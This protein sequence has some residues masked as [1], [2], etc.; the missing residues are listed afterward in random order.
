MRCLDAK[1]YLD[2]FGCNVAGRAVGH[3]GGRLPSWGRPPGEVP[4]DPVAGF[5]STWSDVGSVGRRVFDLLDADVWHDGCHVGQLAGAD[6]TVERC[7]LCEWR[8]PDSVTNRGAE[9][10]G[11]SLG[12]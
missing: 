7:H 9:C 4:G 2:C 11:C 6:A 8:L 5:C 10:S 3:R 12:S 1:E